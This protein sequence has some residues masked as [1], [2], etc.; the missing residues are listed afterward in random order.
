MKCF[1]PLV[2]QRVQQADGSFE[3]V[4]VIL[5][6]IGYRFPDIGKGR[7]MHHGLNPVVFEDF[8]NYAV[9]H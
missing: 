4:F 6:R 8:F 5:F 3:I 9:D 2:D 7:K 1:M